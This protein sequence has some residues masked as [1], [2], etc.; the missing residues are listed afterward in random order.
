[1]RKP[2]GEPRI[3]YN[4]IHQDTIAGRYAGQE[5]DYVF[6]AHSPG[7]TPTSADKLLSIIGEFIEPLPSV[8]IPPY[9][10]GKE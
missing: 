5:W 4:I 3:G 10:N 8:T 6:L 2:I 7:Y 1:L 9:Q